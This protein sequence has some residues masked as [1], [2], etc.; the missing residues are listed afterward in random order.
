MTIDR[1]FDVLDEFREVREFIRAECPHAPTIKRLDAVIAHLSAVPV[2]GEYPHESGD[3]T[4]IG[5]ECFTDAEANVIAYK[6]ENYVRQN[7]YPVGG[8]T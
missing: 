1:D 2:E 7:R 5:P 8:G 3:F 6:G 4:V